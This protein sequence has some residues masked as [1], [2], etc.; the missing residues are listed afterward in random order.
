MSKAIEDLNI[1][2]KLD[3]LY[4]FRI[5]LPANSEYILSSKLRTGTKVEH[6]LKYKVGFNWYQRTVITQ[7]I[8]PDLSTI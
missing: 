2:N 8:F 3:V 4:I 7:T 1:I 6:V 5:L